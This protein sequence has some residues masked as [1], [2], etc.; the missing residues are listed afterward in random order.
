[1][2]DLVG[3]TLR[4]ALVTLAPLRAA[5]DVAGQGR[6]VRQAPAAGGP[7]QPGVTVRVELAPSGEMGRGGAS[8]GRSTDEASGEMARKILDRDR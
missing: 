1:M 2:P 6:V 5:L 3:K 7:L 8:R 4:Q